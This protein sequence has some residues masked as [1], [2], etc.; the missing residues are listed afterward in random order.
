MTETGHTE[1]GKPGKVALVGAGPGDPSLLTLKGKAYIEK[2]DCIIYDR[3][4][5]Q[6]LLHYAS[7][8]CELIYAGKEDRHHTFSQDEINALLYVKAKE[9]NCVVRLKGGDPYVFGRG[10]EEA[11]YL[12][13]R[14]IK[15][16]I[17]PGISSC[18]AVPLYAG[19]PVTHRGVSNGIHIVSAHW[20]ERIDYEALLDPEITY[21]FL[22]GLFGIE[23]IV[24]RLM[25]AGRDPGTPVAVISDGTT[26]KQ[27]ICIACLKTIA[28][29]VKK[30]GLRPPGIIVVG[31]V[32]A[33]SEKLDPFGIAGNG[34]YD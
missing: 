9:K 6:E 24:K 31:N 14:G 1:N 15:A 17:V 22:M 16:E 34:P 33:L 27:R 20:P 12:L 8:G 11:L 5:S 13:E 23:E 3:L 29:K 26:R 2:A 10:G 32:V 19:I 21:V 4:V 30:E 28:D 18:L 7:S 25:E